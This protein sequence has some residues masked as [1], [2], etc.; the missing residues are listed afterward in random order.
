LPIQLELLP[1]NKS[2]DHYLATWS[3]V[4][5]GRRRINVWKRSYPVKKLVVRYGLLVWASVCLSCWMATVTPC[6]AQEAPENHAE[7]DNWRG[8]SLGVRIQRRSG[9]VFVEQVHEHV[10]ADGPLQA[11]D[12]LVSVGGLCLT[13]DRL[14][15]LES[16]LA[17]TAPGSLLRA[18]IERQGKELQLDLPAFRRELVD[19]P[20]IVE[21]LKSNRIIVQ[22]L[23]ETQRSGYLD[24]VFDRMVAAVIHS[25]SPREAA[26]GMNAIIDEIDVS[27]TA[28]LPPFALGR[29]R[30]A[31]PGDLGL[32]LQRHRIDGLP[33]Y[34]VV[35]RMPGSA[36]FESQIL[37]GDEIVSLN[38]VPVEQSRRLILAGQEHR[39]G[40]FFIQVDVD[41]DVEIA[42]RQR[43]NSNCRSASL[44]GRAAV[45]AEQVIQLSARVIESGTNRFGYL[46]FWNLMSM[47]TPALVQ[48]VMA[49]KFAD[50]D[51]LIFD[52]RGRGGLIPAVI[53]VDRV[54]R[55]AGVPVIAITDDLTRSA[56]EM[57][58]L[59][60]KKYPHVTVVGQRT[61]GA[62]TGATMMRLPSGNG[63]MYP[64]VS[65]EAL[66]RFTDDV[67]LEGVG[68]E[69]D[70]EVD[71]Q[72]PWCCGNDRLLEADIETGNL[73][74]QELLDTIF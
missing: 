22:H 1:E 42:F 18:T 37:L 48:Q 12:R 14:D 74:I 16:L 54:I 50:C 68:V 29:L 11:G 38:G 51:M 67:V 21:Q 61:A 53:A 7:Y 65:T 35:D 39:R 70:V 44:Q 27:H 26:E 55:E 43:Q 20:A 40:L 66:K 58:S 73:Q 30:G 62:V 32:T 60:I 24:T 13:S 2:T 5:D 45:P 47:R 72:L 71:F 28:I 49:E 52:L 69:P 6:A 15:Q 31:T 57:L 64:V 25:R 56:K 63:F 8:A 36:G 19:I 34:F 46:R 17:S 41:E 4:A 33:R 3:P 9:Q 10:A 23:Q 59:L